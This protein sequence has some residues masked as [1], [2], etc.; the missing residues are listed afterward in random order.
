[1]SQ[2]PMPGA[3]ERPQPG[4]ERATLSF[5]AMTAVL[6]LS[7]GHISVPE[8]ALPEDGDVIALTVQG[9]CLTG[10]GIYDGDCA[11]I[12][13]QSGA[14]NGDVVA[15]RVKS[16]PTLKLYW[17]DGCKRARLYPVNPA[18]RYSCPVGDDVEIFGKV[19]TIIHPLGG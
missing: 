16:Q 1:M 14:S 12:R 9:D 10:I 2:T 6:E 5:N 8:Q 15:A 19:V 13:L 3:R 11:V 4:P 17:R 18:H 7:D